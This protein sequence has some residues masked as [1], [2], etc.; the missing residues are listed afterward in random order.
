MI[1]V[2]LS[3]NILKRP[4]KYLKIVAAISSLHKIITLFTAVKV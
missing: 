2:I 4:G 3:R 1:S